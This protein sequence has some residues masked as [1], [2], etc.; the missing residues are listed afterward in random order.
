LPGAREAALSG[1]DDYELLFT[2]PVGR[3]E[4]VAALAR[5]LGLPLTRIGRME[6]G[7]RVRVLDETGQEIAPAR[8]G[9]QHF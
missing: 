1:G 8:R 3:R 2:A 4:D 6:A 9:W 5:R 7:S